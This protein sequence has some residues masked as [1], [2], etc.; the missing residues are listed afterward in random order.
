M[1]F[2]ADENFNG[3]ILTGLLVALPDLDIIRVQDTEMYQSPDPELLE[4]AAQEGRIL[5]SHDV[6]TIIGF[7]YDRVR[8]DLLMPGVIEVRYPQGIGV[9]IE[10]LVLLISA[11]TPDEF[12]HQVRYIPLD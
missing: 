10:E 9:A 6:Q 11:S 4:W 1:L 5:L 2:L 3:R 12:E 8:D 7:A